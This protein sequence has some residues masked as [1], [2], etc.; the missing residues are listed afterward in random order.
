MKRFVLVQYGFE[1][2][3]PEVMA[4]WTAWFESIGDRLVTSL[5]FSHGM[6]V[7]HDGTHDLAP[8]GGDATGMS[9]IEA[10]DLA[11]A[12]AVVEACPF[13]DSVHVYEVAM[14]TSNPDR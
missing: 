8:R 3:T 11:A 14:R 4:G 6:R 9:I 2:P 5:G 12:T 1:T 7:D 10:E 13:I